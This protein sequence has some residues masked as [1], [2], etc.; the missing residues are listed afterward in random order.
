MII[1]VLQMPSFGHWK[2]QSS[3][4]YSAGTQVRTSGPVQILVTAVC[5]IIRAVASEQFLYA[6]HGTWITGKVSSRAQLKKIHKFSLLLEYYYYYY[7]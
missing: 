4:T 6:R 7:Y 3:I 5:A 2:N 1:Y